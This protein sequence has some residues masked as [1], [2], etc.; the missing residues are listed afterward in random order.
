MTTNKSKAAMRYAA[1]LCCIYDWSQG[2]MERAPEK[3]GKAD[4]IE[5]ICALGSFLKYNDGPLVTS[6]ENL[7]KQATAVAK[8]VGVKSIEEADKWVLPELVR[9]Y[10]MQKREILAALRL[11]SIFRSEDDL[12]IFDVERLTGTYCW[13]FNGW[14]DFGNKIPWLVVQAI[15][16]LDATKRPWKTLDV[17]EER[18]RLRKEF[19]AK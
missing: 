8:E 5:D 7:C 11:N 18:D 2:E 4:C 10:D 17:F 16:N 14:L 13:E 19:N 12:T 1:R 3:L 15:E 9:T 6:A